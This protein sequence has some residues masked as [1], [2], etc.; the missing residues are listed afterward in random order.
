MGIIQRLPVRL[1]PIPRQ[2]RIIERMDLLSQETRR[3]EANY[4]SRIEVI[5]E[6]RQ[7]ILQKAFSGELTS[8]P[9]QAIKQAAE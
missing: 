7:S 3:L 1:P 2:R 8:P 9:S 6:L 5:E 4:Q